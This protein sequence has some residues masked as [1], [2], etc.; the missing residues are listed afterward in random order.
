[1]DPQRTDKAGRTKLFV[2]T[3][4]GNVAKVQEL[5]D[6]GA[7]VNFKDHAGWVPLHEAALKG[8]VEV[9]EVLIS[10][11]AMLNVRGYGD[12]TPLHDAC[13]NGFAPMVQLLV[14]HGA[15]VYAINADHEQP[16]DVCDNVQCE[17]IIKKKQQQLDQLMTRDSSTGRTSLHKLCEKNDE[18]AV[19]DLLAQGVNTNPEDNEQHWTP[20]H[21]AAHHG[22]LPI[23]QALVR[24]GAIV[25]HVD[26]SGATVLHNACRAGHLA[27]VLFLLENGADLHARD[28]AEKTPYDVATDVDIRRDLAA[29][30][31]DERKQRATSD[32]IDEVTFT[33]LR[34]QRKINTSA[35]KPSPL[36]AAAPR[37]EPLSREERKIAAIM[38][39]F[40]ALEQNHTPPPARRATPA[41]AASSSS[42][43]SPTTA[44]ARRAKRR[45]SS[46]EPTD[47]V[48]KSEKR[49]KKSKTDENAKTDDNSR[50]KNDK[51]DAM[52][53]DSAAPVTMANEK[54]STRG[55]RRNV[56]AKKA[57]H[58][59][60]PSN[61][62]S[63]EASVEAV[64]EGKKKVNVSKLDL[65]KK[66]TCGR[67]HLHRWAIRGDASTVDELLRA[68]ANPNLTDH[69]G[70][71]PLHEASLRGH[72]AVVRLLLEKGAHKD[73][74]GMDQDTPLHDAIDNDHPDVVALLLTAGADPHVRNKEGQSCLE[75]AKA[76]DLPAITQLVQQALDKQAL[77]P[78]EPVD[79][80][81]MGKQPMDKQPLDKQPLEKKASSPPPK[82]PARSSK[83]RRLTVNETR[84]TTPVVA[85]KEEHV[86]IAPPSPPLVK[87]N[88]IRSA[89]ASA[90]SSSTHHRHPMDIHMLTDNTQPES[91]PA[92]QS[93]SST[94]PPRAVAAS[95]ASPNMYH[96]HLHYPHT[97]AQHAPASQ[98]PH[99][100]PSHSQTHPPM[101][102]YGYAPQERVA[103]R[104]YYPDASR[105]ASFSPQHHYPPPPSPYSHA[106]HPQAPHPPVAHHHH[107]PSHPA[108]QQHLQQH[109]QQQ[110]QQAMYHHHHHHHQ[111]P[112]SLYST[113]PPPPQPQPMYRYM[114]GDDPKTPI[115][116]SLADPIIVKQELL[117]PPPPP[118]AAQTM[119]LPT[120]S[121][122]LPAAAAVANNDDSL[123]TEAMR[124]LPLYTV[125]LDDDAYDGGAYMYH[126]RATPQQDSALFVLDLQV[127]RLL[128][129]ST[130]VL[131]QRYPH[132]RRRAVSQKEK[133]RM[134]LPLAKM[135]CASPTSI[136]TA[137][138]KR[139]ATA[140]AENREQE[141]QRFLDQ[142]LY[143]VQ[144]DPIVSLIK[145]D[146]SYLSSK[147][148]TLSLDMSYKQEDAPPRHL[149]H[150]RPSSPSISAA[151]TSSSSSS[152]PPHI[153]NAPPPPASLA[154]TPLKKR[155]LFGLPAKL[156]IKAQKHTM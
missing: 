8:Q 11:G 15:D 108:Q 17:R 14:D 90:S 55:R 43:S 130:H 136:H 91:P 53:V 147:L 115:P 106:H 92:R 68:G 54:G 37:S 16:L 87:K 114:P 6:S 111:A 28:H 144:L 110:Q 64:L 38:K 32:A 112:S 146:Y 156:A 120:S 137:D 39:S 60:K 63:R 138:K 119:H 124:F 121:P 33:T 95:S 151:S 148:I 30:I 101:Y 49:D 126:H 27:I 52:D 24:H 70:Y 94:P 127:S 12:D 82:A 71:T 31:D 154:K 41:R 141:K 100:Y 93:L 132:L 139:K 72:A 88:H 58:S 62:S 45:S 23:V 76:L 103:P 75:L 50:D 67:T 89:S 74:K 36:S 1:M 96:S 99:P 22:H 78:M 113:P 133:E 34:K 59:R 135:L 2:Y 18:F 98:S 128:N 47:D 69:A 86:D 145:H 25:N 5:I 61:A 117:S 123:L 35:K 105:H 65:Q 152:P 9:A 149:L 116:S 73:A 19:L 85:I 150:N 44:A 42:S 29:R 77:D 7:D 104:N 84:L 129:V 83:K 21:V 143:F 80:Q 56:N 20:L 107:P 10:H 97:H 125:Q 122:L 118:L 57:T 46:L 48:E 3:G 66:D 81:P 134:W 13:A 142:P 109:Q 51:N 155:H 79:K 40:E 131:W 4:S 140:L 26:I 102:E 153:V